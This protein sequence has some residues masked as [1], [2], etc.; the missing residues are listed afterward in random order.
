MNP[1][2]FKWASQVVLLVKDLPAKAG[3]VGRKV[4]GSILMSGRFPGGA[5]GTPVFLHGESHGK[6]SLADYSP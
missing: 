3:G 2:I 1:H 5:H 6:R 4:V